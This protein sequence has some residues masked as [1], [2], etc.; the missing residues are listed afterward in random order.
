M[1]HSYLVHPLH[2]L[3]GLFEFVFYDQIVHDKG[4]TNPIP[5][6]VEQLAVLVHG[7]LQS[8]SLGVLA[9]SWGAYLLYEL[10]ARDTNL[11]LSHAILVSPV[12]L[13][14]ERFDASGGRIV[15]RIPDAVMSEMQSLAA[16][17][18]DR[19]VMDLIYPYYLAQRNRHMAC[20]VGR[21]SNSDNE[22]IIAAIGDYDF[23][24][25]GSR[26]PSRTLLVYGDE[27][28]ECPAD[29]SELHGHGQ[30]QTIEGAG[31]FSFCEQPERFRLAVLNRFGPHQP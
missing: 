21:Y 19:E 18:K 31:H 20:P 9:H 4:E 7:C 5:Q 29:T 2:G 10:L 22:R 6:L 24:S 27:D 8:G 30:V 11:V 23:R 1:D 13:T 16:D 15:S 17:G 25:L 12:G 14:K 26:L 28:I 3:S